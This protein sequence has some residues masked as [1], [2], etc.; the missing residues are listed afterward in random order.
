METTM[1]RLQ[2]NEKDLL[3]KFGDSLDGIDDV[4]ELNDMGF[5]KF[6]KGVWPR[7][8]GNVF[9]MKKVLRKYKRQL[10]DSFGD[11]FSS[12]DWDAKVPDYFI[13]PTRVNGGIAMVLNGRLDKIKF[14]EYLN[15]HRGFKSNGMR[16]NGE[17]WIAPFSFDFES[18]KN[19]MANLGIDMTPVPEISVQEL[20]QSEQE[21][22]KKQ[23]MTLGE[24]EA[25]VELLENGMFAIR[26]PYSEKMNS[27]YWNAEEFGGIVKWDRER[28]CRV[29]GAGEDGDLKDVIALLKKIHPEWAVAIHPLVGAELKKIAGSRILYRT[30]EDWIGAYYKPET[31]LFPYQVEGV[32][33][34]RDHDGNAL[35]GDD[36]GL[37]KTLQVLTW[38]ATQKKSILVIC[39]KNVRRQWLKEADKFFLPGTFN[40]FEIDTQ[41]AVDQVKNAL[42]AE[43]YNLIT[44]NYQILRK[45]QEVL[46]LAGIDVMVLDESHRIKSE[47]AAITKD[48][49]AMAKGFKHHILMSGTPIKN[50]KN[51][52]YTQANIIEPGVFT[53]KYHV[54]MMPVFDV[55][56][57]MKSFF[58]RRI[59]TRELKDLPPKL[60]EITE[61]VTEDELPDYKPGMEIGEISSLKSQLAIAKT[62]YTID[63]ID[64]ILENTESKIIV[65]S[66]SDDACQ[67]IANHY[68]DQAVIHIG[69]T[70]HEQR[71]KN[72]E[73]FSD[74]NS[75]VRVFVATTGSAQ[76]G[77]NLQV[78]DKLIFNDLPWVPGTIN[79]AED[80]AWRLGQ[81]KCVNVYWMVARVSAFDIRVCDILWSKMSI[82]KKL[83]DGKKTTAEEMEIMKKR[84]TPEE[85][86]NGL[87]TKK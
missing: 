49:T 30:M 65:F 76:E 3:V 18:Y 46:Q 55:R 51:E 40:G 74:E 1:M 29:V 22:I 53:S 43:K 85:I 54:T 36:M 67:I 6:D 7:C 41:M 80:R 25:R 39:P 16:F 31:K 34:L 62:K 44:I 23:A 10:T 5:N 82:F 15:I 35:I 14:Q 26:H 86:M 66:D 24:K 32:K 48:V 81:K 61:I 50:K 12:I 19:S 72:K 58:F 21:A 8:R 38:A 78:A 9:G 70:K 77:L 69:S 60:R 27:A 28:K 52:I 17:S 57:K 73:I 20:E 45:Y 75:K 68:G 11:E 59:K 4:R 37:G 56:E 64:D 84:I 79:Q 33:I 63:F 87:V 2:V 47:K 83:I 13:I 42:K 71:E